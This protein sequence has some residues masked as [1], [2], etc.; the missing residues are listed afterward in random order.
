[1]NTDAVDDNR[2]AGW[3]DPISLQTKNV[4]DK[5]DKYDKT[6][7]EC[8]VYL[9][10]S[11]FFASSSPFSEHVTAVEVNGPHY[12]LFSNSVLYTMDA[13]DD[14]SESSTYDMDS[15]D[16]NAEARPPVLRDL[17][18]GVLNMTLPERSAFLP[19]VDKYLHTQALFFMSLHHVSGTLPKTCAQS[20]AH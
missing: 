8:V 16:S 20:P 1:M 14:G 5:G 7:A 10:S 9:L 12:D 2:G 11:M 6:T 18:T 3:P 19:L 13:A 4:A 15:I 17:W